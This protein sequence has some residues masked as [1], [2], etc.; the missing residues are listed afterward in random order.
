MGRN[1]PRPGQPVFSN[2]GTY[3]GSITL[4]DEGAGRVKIEGAGHAAWLPLDVVEEVAKRYVLLRIRRYEVDA[5]R[6]ARQGARIRARGTRA[7]NR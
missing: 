4:V 5:R 2:D 1:L 7:P 3:L 6:W